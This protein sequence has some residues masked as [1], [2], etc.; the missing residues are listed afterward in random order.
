MPSS[1]SVQKPTGGD[2]PSRAHHLP[3]LSFS[4]MSAHSRR[5]QKFLP[6]DSEKYDWLRSVQFQAQA[7]GEFKDLHIDN[8]RLEGQDQHIGMER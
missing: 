7:Q 4:T 3:G 2:P 8:C 5:V 6:W 1:L